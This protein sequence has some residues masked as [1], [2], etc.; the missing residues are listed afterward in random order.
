MCALSCLSVQADEQKKEH[1]FELGRSTNGNYVCYD[2]NLQQ[3]GNL[4]LKQPLRAY[5][6]LSQRTDSLSFLDKKMAFGVKVV[7]AEK[8]EA[9][10]HLTAYKG[11]PIHI[12]K[13]KG[14]W[15]G[16]VKQ[17]GHEMILQRLFAQMKPPF[18]VRCEYVDVYG[19]DIKTGEKRRER[20]TP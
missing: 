14:K 18:S 2:I 8:N 10:I 13:H 16:I 9:V 15:V 7:K 19:I 12:C 11:L 17:N 6:Q 3:D 4:Y 20:I 5:W 1:V